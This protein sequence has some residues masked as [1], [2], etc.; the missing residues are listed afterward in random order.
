MEPMEPTVQW[1]TNK[2]TIQWDTNKPISYHFK[3]MRI[4]DTAI[5]NIE[6]LGDIWVFYNIK[7]DEW[8]AKRYLG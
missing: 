4:I 2:P 7:Y 8:W 1:D 6:P 5:H 3:I